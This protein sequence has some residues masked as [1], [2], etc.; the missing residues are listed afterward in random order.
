MFK[1]GS[2]I[3]LV[4]PVL[5]LGGLLWSCAPGRFIPP[6]N[7]VTIGGT[8][9]VPGFTPDTVRAIPGDYIL[10]PNPF[11]V[12]VSVELMD[13]PLRPARQRIPA[14]GT[15]KVQVL[16]D[17]DEGVYKYNVVVTSRNDTIVVVDPHIDV[18]ERRDGRGD[19]GG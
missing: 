11:G 1:G 16:P 17:A 4:L 7:R 8:Q 10:W 14:G 18:G 19:S 3:W 13:A 2:R 15:G 5:I 6:R 9:V 12:T